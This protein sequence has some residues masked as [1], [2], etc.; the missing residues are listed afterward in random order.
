[1][2]HVRSIINVIE[3]LV[4]FVTHH[5]MHRQKYVY[6]DFFL[7]AYN[8]ID[9]SCRYAQPLF[10]GQKIPIV[11]TLFFFV[12]FHFF[13][14]REGQTSVRR[15]V[16]CINENYATTCIVLGTNNLYHLMTIRSLTEKELSFDWFLIDNRVLFEL[17][18]LSCAFK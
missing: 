14:F 3:R 16:D 9:V 7:F 12:F 15:I 10:I 11:V 2:I 1:M 18:Q 6:F 13:S 17:P 5:R 4:S 8:F